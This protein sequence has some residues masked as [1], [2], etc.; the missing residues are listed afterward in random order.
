M[1]YR[2]RMHILT[3]RMQFLPGSGGRIGY[4]CKCTSDEHADNDY[5]VVPIRLGV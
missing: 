3:R 5:G 1:R 2:R 4:C